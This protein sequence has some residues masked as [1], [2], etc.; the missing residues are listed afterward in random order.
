VQLT[1]DVLPR[2]ASHDPHVGH[3]AVID[4]P[5]RTIGAHQ[6][7]EIL[8]GQVAQVRRYFVP[9]LV[10]VALR[11]ESRALGIACSAGRSKEPDVVKHA[12]SGRASG[13]SE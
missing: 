9:V 10:D 7:H 12:P 13:S 6:R 2:E 1:R 3:R 8:D 4:A 11:D 5:G